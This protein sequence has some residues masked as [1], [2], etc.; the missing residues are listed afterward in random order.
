M[1]RSKNMLVRNKT[2]FICILIIWSKNWNTTNKTKNQ[3]VFHSTITLSL[4]LPGVLLL[5][6]D[7][8]ER[9]AGLAPKSGSIYWGWSHQCNYGHTGNA[10]CQVR[11]P[12]PEGN[13]KTFECWISIRDNAFVYFDALINFFS[14]RPK[15]HGVVSVANFRKENA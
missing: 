2:L 3:S 14:F 9:W 5:N 8:L 7:F 1:L 12:V 10:P 11:T 4:Q 6:S 15:I 13:V